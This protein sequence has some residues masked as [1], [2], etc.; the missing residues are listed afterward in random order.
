MAISPQRIS[1][2]YS[3]LR[4]FCAPI[5]LFSILGHLGALYEVGQWFG[6]NSLNIQ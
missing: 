2:G 6:G 4:S 5:G 3:G 1:E